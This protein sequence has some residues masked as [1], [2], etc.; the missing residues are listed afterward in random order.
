MMLE[1][2]LEKR[3]GSITIML[4]FLLISVLSIN[5]T[6]METSRYWGIKRLYKELEESAAFS[7]LSNYDRDLFGNYGLLGMSEKVN[8]DTFLDYLESS[9]NRNLADVN[10]ADTFLD[11][12]G[13]EI[14]FEKLYDLAQQEVF[15]AQIDEFCAYRAPVSFVNNT[16]NM[17]EMLKELIKDLEESLPILQMFNNL[18]KSAEKIFNTFSSLAD[19]QE[20]CKNLEEHYNE[21]QNCVE[22]FNKAVED[23][24]NY[25]NAEHDED[26]DYEG[27]LE[28]KCNEVKAKAVVLRNSIKSTEA[29]LGEFYEGYKKFVSAFDGMQAANVKSMLSGAR[30]DVASISNENVRK[31]YEETLDNMEDAYKD[32]EEM[33]SSIT[34]R[35]DKFKEDNVRASVDRLEQQWESLE[36][37]G[38]TLGKTECKEIVGGDSVWD[39]V[40]LMAG[41]MQQIVRLAEDWAKAFATIGD[42]LEVMKYMSTYG[43]YD[44]DCDSV[45]S[46]SFASQL[47][48][49]QRNGSR[50]VHAAN[51]YQMQDEGEVRSQIAETEEIASYVGFDTGILNIN[52]NENE[53]LLLQQAMA[54]MLNAETSFRGECENLKSSFGIFSILSALIKVVSTLIELIGSIINLIYAFIHAAGTGELE[55]LLYQKF[56]ATVY[57][58]EMFSNR[59]TDVSSD[60]RL[61][62][63]SFSDNVRIGS[64]NDTCF[65]KADVEYILYGSNS[66]ILNQE[67]VFLWILAMRMLCNIPAL[68]SNEMV[69]DVVE[70]LCESIVG[71]IVGI[72]I[73]LVV[74][75]LEA[76]LDMLF[77]ICGK[78]E[79]D[80]IK[81]TG[82][83]TIDSQ[84]GINEDFK[85]KV[86]NLING[87]EL[88]EGKSENKQSKVEKYGKGLLQWGYKDHLFLMLTLFVPS[89]TIYARSADLIEMQMKRQKAI[90]GED[91]KLS[92]MA[93]YVRIEST[94]TY[95]PLLPVPI[96]PGLNDEGLKIKNI[97]Y[98]GY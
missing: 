20:N 52:Q 78:D 37:E 50:M 22:A 14:S 16:F 46:S 56:N 92:E 89:K 7:V 59:I 10:G 75:T 61:N 5:S 70:G 28:S 18:C 98:S 79:V 23:R 41:T 38:E 93:T 60:K 35:M 96:I 82:Y 67:N 45:L 9:L 83:L 44:A 19:Y 13:E 47:A 40:R 48:G 1:L 15:A 12:M 34:E 36:G 90:S 55:K 3:R 30:A 69:M 91:F 54:K 57:A 29:A 21:Y 74:L 77:M 65:E 17:E 43:L 72:I 85:K 49:R 4:S 84:G 53:N 80:I 73:L 71:A 8:K 6:L 86:E 2:F 97:H 33:C 95:K 63:S 62:G 42:L 51:P 94:V 68:L 87:V 81:L 39:T 11:I 64:R 66:E 24:D 32:S 31:G 58:S 88:S 25:I 76:W 27:N 26:E